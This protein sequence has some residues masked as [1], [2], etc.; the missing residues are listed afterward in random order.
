MASPCRV[1]LDPR[2]LDIDRQLVRGAAVER[3]AAA[4]GKSASSV[5]RHRDQHLSK[6]IELARV[7][8]KLDGLDLHTEIATLKSELMQLQEQGRE[9]GDWKQELAIF[10]RRLRLL[11]LQA[12]LSGETKPEHQTNVLNL[13]LDP[14]T[15]VRM[16]E[17]FLARQKFLK[18]KRDQ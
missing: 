1:C 3:V 13:N 7:G 12:K 10:D 4:F 16:A 18:N 11:E 15:A 5:R 17:T 6:A 2:R 8:D 9:S 14:K